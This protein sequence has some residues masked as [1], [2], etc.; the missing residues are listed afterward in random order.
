MAII[1]NEELSVLRKQFTEGIVPVTFI[2]APINAALQA[3]NDWF[4]KAAVQSSLNTDIEAAAAGVFTAN[5]KKKLVKFW[6]RSR[7]EKE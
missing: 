5:Q 2:K 1:T 4:D 3:I 6:L 7:F